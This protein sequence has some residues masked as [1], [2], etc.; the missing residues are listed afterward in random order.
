MNV[1]DVMT[2]WK[3]HAL[4]KTLSVY[5]LK[6]IDMIHRYYNSRITTMQRMDDVNNDTNSGVMSRL[7]QIL[8]LKFKHS[9]HWYSVYILII[10]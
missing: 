4:C 6:L 7:W 2:D 10:A 3:K 5:R 9:L 8:Y 1:A